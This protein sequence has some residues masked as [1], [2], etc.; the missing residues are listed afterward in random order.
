M[1]PSEQSWTREIALSPALALFL[2][3]PVL[4]ELVSAYQAPL[5][6]LNP[7]RL[8]ITLVPYGCGALVV[9]ELL[10]RRRRGWVSPVLLAEM[11]YPQRRHQAWLGTAALI[12]CCVALP[13]WALVLELFVPYVPPLGGI[14]GLVGK[15]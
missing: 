10:V 12:G 15:E 6:F 4:G 11:L 7:L 13:G 3:A 2:I 9:R 1:Q 5:E 14:V 8:A